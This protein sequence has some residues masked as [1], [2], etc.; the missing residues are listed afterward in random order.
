MISMFMR[1]DVIVMSSA[2]VMNSTG[3]C[4]VG[5]SYLYMLH[6]V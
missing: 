5:V 4:G 3:S 2:Y 1:V 6:N